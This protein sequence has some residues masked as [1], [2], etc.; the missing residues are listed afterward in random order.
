[1]PHPKLTHARLDRR[2]FLGMT[3]A[4]AAGLV[5][6]D[7]AA[8][9]VAAAPPERRT[10]PLGH[11]LR[12]G[13]PQQVGIDPDR[14]E[15]VFARLS[16]RAADGRFPGAVALVARHGRVVGFRAT[17]TKVAGKREP[18]T[19]DTLFDLESMTK[20]MATS[21]AALIL[22]EQGRLRLQDR[23]ARYLP[24]FAA[25]GKGNIVVRDMLRYSAGLPVDNQKVDTNDRDAIWR[26]MERTPLEYDPG[27]SVEYS[28]LTYRLL[29]RLIERV[30][31]TDLDTFSRRVIWKPLGMHSTMYNPPARLR[32]RC[33]ATG[34]GSLGLRP[35]PLRG[36][37]QDDQ[38]WKLGG[39]VG[40]DG[41]FS[42]AYDVA[43]FCQMLLNGGTYGGR[44]ILDRRLVAAM[45]H[46]QT[47]QVKAAATDQDP[48]TN[49]LFTPKGYGFEIWTHR[50]SPGGMLLSEGSYGKTGGAG[51]FMWIDPHRDLFAV[52]L[53]NHGLPIPF[54]QPGWNALI[55]EVAPGE[56]YDGV[57]TA[58]LR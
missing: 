50:F 3:G 43:I 2:R 58:L 16:R 39:I 31:G 53:T 8:T 47:P 56:F 30:A 27:T 38:D 1:M 48:T 26:F 46:N 55:D 9:K 42:S 14:L 21:T 41:A 13:H 17:G 52:L 51:T 32:A 35:G 37:V 54:D 5:V 6:G 57:V 25:H 45:V 18:V 33:A 4:T 28:D 15:D 22:V 49:L 23:V 34:P 29:G 20:V 24:E 40:C 44:R 19:K 10:G 7:A 36:S 12:Q 11:V